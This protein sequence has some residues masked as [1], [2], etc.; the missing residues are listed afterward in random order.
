AS[1]PSTQLSFPRTIVAIVILHTPVMMALTQPATLRSNSLS[2]GALFAD[3][4][5]FACGWCL[6]ARSH[7]SV[8]P[9][10]RGAFDRPRQLQLEDIKHTDGILM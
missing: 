8:Q 10:Q 3:P 4:H 9:C 5:I 2:V 6:G 7:S 1:P